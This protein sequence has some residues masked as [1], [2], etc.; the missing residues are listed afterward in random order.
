MGGIGVGLV[1]DVDR[2]FVYEVYIKN[3][4]K[5]IGIIGNVK[6]NS[7]WYWEILVYC[8][9]NFQVIIYRGGVDFGSLS[10]DRIVRKIIFFFRE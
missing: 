9:K 8:C 2:V 5:S 4:I 1:R 3:K 7:L 10:E 6:V